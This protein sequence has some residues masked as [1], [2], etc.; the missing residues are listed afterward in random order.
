MTLEKE[1]EKKTEKTNTIKTE[2]INKEELFNN[3]KIVP[4][5]KFVNMLEMFLLIVPE[6]MEK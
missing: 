3:F 6:K 5:D 4:K 2:L 1:A